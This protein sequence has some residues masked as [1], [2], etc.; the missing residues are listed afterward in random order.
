MQ[1]QQACSK[2]GGGG[3]AVHA[4]GQGQ[5]A[6]EGTHV[7]FTED[8]FA[9][10]VGFALS[11]DDQFTAL[12]GQLKIFLPQPGHLER[13][14]VGVAFVA[15]FGLREDAVVLNAAFH[16]VIDRVADGQQFFKV[17][18]GAEA[19]E[20]HTQTIAPSPPVAATMG[21]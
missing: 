1:D 15:Q 4:G 7:E 5:G 2:A 12:H 9:R 16:Q 21:A 19:V 17:V 6:L 3:C 10:V 11:S 18:G 8:P 13:H 14:A 20:L